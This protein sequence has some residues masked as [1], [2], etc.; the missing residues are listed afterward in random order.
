MNGFTDKDIIQ[1]EKIEQIEL[2]LED[3]THMSVLNIFRNLKVLIL[4]N[5]GLTEIKVGI[6]LS[7]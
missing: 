3:F 4:I 1:P 6:I 7:L 2:C 5:V